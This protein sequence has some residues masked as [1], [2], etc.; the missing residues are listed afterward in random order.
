MG[1]PG[2]SSLPY[3][4]SRWHLPHRQ[5]QQLQL[6]P[7]RQR[8]LRRPPPPLS[9]LLLQQPDLPLLQLLHLLQEAQ[10]RSHSI[11]P[12]SP[13]S[14][15]S[16]SRYGRYGS[17]MGQTGDLRSNR[18]TLCWCH[19]PRALRALSNSKSRTQLRILT[20]SRY[21]VDTVVQWVRV[22][23]D[24]SNAPT[25]ICFVC[26]RLSASSRPA[27]RSLSRL[28]FDL[29]CSTHLW[30][31]QIFQTSA[32]IPEENRH[33]FAIY[34]KKCTADEAK[35]QPRNVGYGSPTGQRDDSFS[36]GSQTRSPTVW[37]VFWRRS[38]LRRP[39]IN[40]LLPRRRYGSSMGQRDDWLIAGGKE[41]REKGGE[42]V[43]DDWI[44]E[45]IRANKWI[46]WR[47]IAVFDR[48]FIYRILQRE[49]NVTVAW[50]SLIDC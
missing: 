44:N 17:S 11:W 39:P 19:G 23:I 8:P 50:N 4:P 1:Y 18:T 40:R 37:S 13:E 25:T 20:L 7:R 16:N 43:M 2:V 31:L 36:C 35:N 12:I 15:P 49:R 29:W 47:P 24:R 42:E 22:V 48:N 9:L 26:V 46:N 38:R 5:L 28:I 30:S 41:R 32:E 27:N 10:P 21:T 3:P 33:F 6:Q 14:P 34:H 45:L